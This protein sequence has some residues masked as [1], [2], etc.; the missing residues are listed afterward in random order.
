LLR[1]HHYYPSPFKN[2]W[3]TQTPQIEEMGLG[4]LW[5]PIWSFEMKKG[6]IRPA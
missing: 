6:G 5:G 2:H 3:I 1:P 4:L